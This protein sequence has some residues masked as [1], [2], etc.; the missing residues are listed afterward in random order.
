MAISGESPEVPEYTFT[1]L[2][3]SAGG[4]IKP[5]GANGETGAASNEPPWMP[6]EDCRQ[7]AGNRPVYAD[8]YILQTHEILIHHVKFDLF[9]RVLQSA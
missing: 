5:K 6:D 9:S 2:P 7:K 8:F 1:R 3:M 4:L